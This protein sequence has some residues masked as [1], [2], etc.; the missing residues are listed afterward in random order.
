MNGTIG[1][2]ILP[3]LVGIAGG[4]WG[5]VPTFFMSGGPILPLVSVGDDGENEIWAPIL[6]LLTSL[7]YLFA[8]AVSVWPTRARAA[9]LIGVALLT[10]ILGIVVIGAEGVPGGILWFCVFPA[11]VLLLA[12][13]GTSLIEMRRARR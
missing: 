8:V 13:A 7:L 9:L 5:F 2:T 10:V 6:L 3:S 4:L 1:R 11:S 12:A